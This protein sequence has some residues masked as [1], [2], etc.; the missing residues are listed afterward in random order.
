MYGKLFLPFYAER[1]IASIRRLTLALSMRITGGIARGIP[2]R[3]PHGD[4]T[5]PA[6][7]GMRQALFNSMAMR[8][9]GSRVLDLFAGSGAY[10]L[11]AL[12]RGAAH[13]TF[14]ERS[15]KALACIRQNL[16]AVCKAVGT[17]ISDTSLVLPLD[18]TSALG[19][20]EPLPDLV[21]IDPPY[22]IIPSV[23]PLLFARLDALLAGVA[24]PLVAFEM[25]GELSISPA[26][27]SCVKRLGK[28][29]PRQ[30]TVALFRRDLK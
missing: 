18:A 6:T 3:A 8:I 9:A 15:P 27:W 14:V 7:D 24:D 29:A 16:A 4:A 2:L 26:G 22:E 11:E 19:L 25:P 20:A 10:G 13:A 17:N 1:R 30:P 23:A 21:F 12:S 28:C 5:R